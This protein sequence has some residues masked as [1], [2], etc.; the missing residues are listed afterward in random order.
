MASDISITYDLLFDILRSEKS[1][2]ELQVLDEGFY[3]N[4]ASY[5]KDKEQILINPGT[6]TAERELTRIQLN[7]VKKILLEL[8][9]KRE[10]KII[11]LASYRIKTGS[12]NHNALLQEEK[13]FF[14]ATYDLFSRYRGMVINNVLN[15]KNPEINEFD[16]S[17]SRST[18]SM[19]EN[20]KEQI[21]STPIIDENQITS[22]RFVRPVPKFL[23][24]DMETYGPF[25][26]QDMASLPARIA[27][28]LIT[29][30]RAEEV[31]SD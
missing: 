3:A 30:E 26:E 20:K 9:E 13:F 5:I 21:L 18:S 28:V 12:A 7:N 19:P 24:P 17:E 15:S 14:D 8:Y 16:S 22:V 4:V 1:K 23:G 31:K 10:R 29:K 11:N 25:E 2:E 27:H 6:P